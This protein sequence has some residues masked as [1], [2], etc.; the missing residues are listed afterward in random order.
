[1]GALRL[2]LATVTAAIDIAPGF[3]RLELR[4]DAL[5]GRRITPG[6]KVQLFVGGTRTYTP[7]AFDAATG[8]FSVVGFVHGEGPGA[9][10]IQSARVNDTV[11]LFGP[12]GSLDVDVDGDVVLV[13]DATSVGVAAALAGARKPTRR[14]I[15]LIG[16]GS[17]AAAAAAVDVDA[18]CSA[19]IDDDVRA[20]VGS[21]ARV[22]LTGGVGLIQALKP[23]A[24]ERPKAKAYWAPGKRGLD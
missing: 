2:P 8:A 11:R 14:R 10:F 13:G 3:R 6:D 1:M 16:G 4:A 18:V 20:A 7:F 5:R 23:L 21:D 24:K 22:F 9:A 17:L 12:R 15:Y 19:A